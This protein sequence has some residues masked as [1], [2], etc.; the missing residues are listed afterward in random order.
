[1]VKPKGKSDEAVIAV[2]ADRGITMVEGL[3]PGIT[4][5]TT[6]DPDVHMMGMIM[7]EPANLNADNINLQLCDSYVLV[8]KQLLTGKCDAGIFLAEA[9]HD[10]SSLVREPLRVLVSSEIQVIHHS[11]MLGPTLA[12]YRDRLCE[13]LVAMPEDE[14]G[15]NVLSTLGVPG[16]VRV[17]HE[18]A[19]FMVDLMDTLLV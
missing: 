2:A 3:T 19:E 16:W 1:L 6:A 7:L 14:K 18:A 10:L 13:M 17:D 4:V 11:L 5:A 9:F 8:A 15:R 12:Q